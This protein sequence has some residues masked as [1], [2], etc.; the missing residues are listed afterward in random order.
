M[1]PKKV[2]DLTTGKFLPEEPFFS[3]R[4]AEEVSFSCANS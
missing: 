4:H 3:V 2:P 1:D